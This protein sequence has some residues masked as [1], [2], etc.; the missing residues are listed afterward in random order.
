MAK[1]GLLMMLIAAAFIGGAAYAPFLPTAMYHA[2][3]VLRPQNLWA[4]DLSAYIS[5][6]FPFSM[7]LAMIA[8]AA[9]GTNRIGFWVAPHRF[10]GA[11][12]PKGNIGHVAMFVFAVWVTTSFLNAEHPEAGADVFTDYRKIFLMFFVTCAVMLRVKQ[13]LALVI[14]AAGSLSYIGLEVNELYLMNGRYNFLP[15][16]GFAGLD[17]NGAALMLAIGFPLCIFLWDGLNHWSRWIFPIGAACIAHAVMLS[18]SR[19]GM[20]SLLLTSPLYAMRCRNRKLVF[21][22]YAAAMVIVPFFA[23]NEISAR[24]S[25]IGEH[26]KDESAGS[27]KT[28]WAIAIRMGFERPLFGF[29]VRNSS[30]Y[31]FQYG[32]DCEGRVIHSTYF[33]I[34]AD[35]GA[36]GLASYLF[37]LGS[38]FYCANRVRRAVKPA[39]IQGDDEA[40]YAYT[41]ACAV[42]G[43]L[44]VWAVGCTFLSLETFEPPYLMMVI[45]IQLWSI[46][47][48]QRARPA[49]T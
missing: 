41:T 28:T 17:N 29:G 47:A 42:E 2:F 26:D 34:M 5:P 11:K 39:A 18:Y 44:A 37:L 40:R 1:I 23:S 14:I 6:D 24:F 9:A 25:S 35:S 31:T 21:L 49:I 12:L 7:L 10:P 13:A 19:G 22:G 16:H 45:A 32:A 8:I 3:S 30:L 4:H 33:Q 48:M 43:A 38:G 46:V 20:L 27:R 36:C 15:N